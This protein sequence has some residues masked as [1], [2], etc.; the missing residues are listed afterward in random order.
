[1]SDQVFQRFGERRAVSEV[2][3]VTRCVRVKVSDEVCQRLGECRD[4]SEIS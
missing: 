3:R 1:M 4:V 2:R